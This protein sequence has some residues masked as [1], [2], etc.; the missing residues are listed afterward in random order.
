MSPLRRFDTPKN[1]ISKLTLNERVILPILIKA[2]EK[3]DELYQ[4][5]END[6]YPGANF[7]PHDVKKEDVEKFN[8]L[9]Q[10]ILDPFTVVVKK[11]DKL[12]TVPYHKIYE[13]QLKPIA[14]LIKKAA[15]FCKNKSFKNYLLS[16]EKAVLSDFYQEADIAWLAIKGSNLT[17]T[18]GPFERNLDRLFFIKRAYQAHVGILD[19][20]KTQEAKVMRDVI[21]AS[22]GESA[23]R[24]IPPTIVDISIEYNLLS[25]GLIGRLFFTQQHLPSDAK[26]IE[27]YG[28]KVIVYLAS[29]NQKFDEYIYPIFEA[30]FEESFKSGYS[31]ELLAIANYRHILLHSIAQQLH[32]YKES[33]ARLRELFPIY[34]EANSIGAAIQATKPLVLK[35]VLNQKELEAII[36][37]HICWIFSEWVFAQETTSREAYLKGDAL[38]LNFLLG[39]GALQ[40]QNGISWPNFAKMFFEIENMTNKFSSFLEYGSYWEALEYLDKYL[41]YGIFEAFTQRLSG[42]KKAK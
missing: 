34:D 27:N 20:E 22:V 41:S 8:A 9:N 35:G 31:K 28:S 40:Q 13:K 21:Y 7:Y 2:A 5:Q 39:E 26:T 23:K 38:T 6:K 3:I 18:L 32:R 10:K 14:R 25:A 17:M 42:I 33:R 16:L 11:G 19:S 37:C 15:A 30:I 36:I 1:L 24:I 12:D 4:L 29:V